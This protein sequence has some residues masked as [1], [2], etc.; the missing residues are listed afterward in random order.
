MTQHR[1]QPDQDKGEL[2]TPEDQQIST[3]ASS[4]S[5]SSPPSSGAA[6]RLGAGVAE[7][8]V[9][10]PS[11]DLERAL[12]R[13]GTVLPVVGLLVMGVAWYRASG[14]GYDAEQIPYL[15]SGGLV[16]LGW[17]LIGLGLFLRYSLTRLLRFGV[18]RMVHEQQAQADR[19]VEAIARL[20]QAI[21]DA[22]PTAS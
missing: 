17:V 10:E 2:A 11:A 18:A 6:A 12:L 9:P 15:I 22:E 20:E 16:G 14:T 13:L 7:L 4:S 21:R 5:S 19:M 3:E 1:D 8:H